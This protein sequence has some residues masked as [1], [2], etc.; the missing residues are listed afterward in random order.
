MWVQQRLALTW[1]I[2]TLHAVDSYVAHYLTDDWL[3]LLKIPLIV[4]QPTHLH[5]VAHNV[6][7]CS[8]NSSVCQVH[9]TFLMGF[10]DSVGQSVCFTV[11]FCCDKNDRNETTDWEIYK[12]EERDADQVWKKREYIAIYVNVTAYSKTLKITITS[13]QEYHDNMVLCGLSGLPPLRVPPGFIQRIWFQSWPIST[14]VF[15]TWINTAFMNAPVYSFF[16]WI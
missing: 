7:Q 10:N 2:W 15:L 14:V 4:Q 1:D 11:L 13:H 16:S 12:V 5:S 8:T 6:T 3:L 9:A